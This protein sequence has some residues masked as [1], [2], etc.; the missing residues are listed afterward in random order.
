[1]VGPFVEIQGNVTIGNKVRI[2]SHS[3]ICEN[4]Q[5]LDSTFIGHGVMFTN[6]KFTDGKLTKDFLPTKVGYRCRIGSNVTILPVSICD[7]V[8]IGAGS[9]V[10]KDITRRGVYAGN[11]AV[12]IK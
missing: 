3:F 9:V 7:D 10:T 8:V 4:T 1:M 2:Q 12:R 6:D 5:I 11:P